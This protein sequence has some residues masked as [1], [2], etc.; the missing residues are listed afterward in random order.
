MR[1]EYDPLTGSGGAAPRSR[2]APSLRQGR[3]AT[4][5]SALAKGAA[6]GVRNTCTCLIE[7]GAGVTS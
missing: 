2:K 5:F 6:K 4:S 1:V 7:T 3:F